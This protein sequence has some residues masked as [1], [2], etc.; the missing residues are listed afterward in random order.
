MGASAKQYAGNPFQWLHSWLHQGNATVSH[1]P[2][3]DYTTLAL[4]LSACRNGEEMVPVLASIQQR[5]RTIF[6]DCS[7]SDLCLLLPG[8]AG[9]HLE[10]I[11]GGEFSDTLQQALRGH[12]G[13]LR[14]QQGTEHPLPDVLYVPEIPKGA[15]LLQMLECGGQSAWLALYFRGFHPPAER[16][17]YLTSGLRDALTR[18][19]EIYLRHR[20]TVQDAVREE[21]AT[22]AAELHDSMAQVLGYLRMRTAR[23]Q[24]LCHNELGSDEQA[25]RDY[26]DDLA[27]Q[28]LFAYRQMRELIST[29]RLRLKEETLDRALASAVEELEQHSGIVFELDNRCPQLHL[30]P[31]QLIQLSYIARESLANIVRHSHATHARILVSQKHHRL[32]MRIEDN[33]LGIRPDQARTDSFGLKIMQER[34]ERIGARLSIAPLRQGGTRV[35]LILILAQ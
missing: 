8:T 20:A 21:R 27:S 3:P 16:V 13:Q 15:L 26:A 4:E 9:D 32:R 18:G 28:T 22:Q 35:E 19:L 25:I 29:S 1:R 12:I 31:E 6:F 5:I 17:A 10:C 7:E 11:A 30:S 14:P 24:S 2:D 33:G 23:L 34:A